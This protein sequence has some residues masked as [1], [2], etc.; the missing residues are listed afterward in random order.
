MEKIINILVPG[1]IVQVEYDD[2]N[3]QVVFKIKEAKLLKN[4]SIIYSSVN[5]GEFYNN[6]ISER[7]FIM[8]RKD[9]SPTLLIHSRVEDFK[10][11][12]TGHLIK[13]IKL[14]KKSK[15]REFIEKREKCNTSCPARTGMIECEKENC[16]FFKKISGALLGDDIVIET[17]GG[18]G[19][20]KYE[21]SF[22]L[23]A[24]D[25][26]DK[27]QSRYYYSQNLETDLEKISNRPY[28]PIT[29]T[30]NSF[31]Y[32]NDFKVEKDNSLLVSPETLVQCDNCLFEKGS[33]ECYGCA[34]K[35]FEVEKV[36]NYVKL[37]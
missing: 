7:D 18:S 21:Y 5:R 35:D 12:P 4:K 30:I 8:F 32:Y 20:K 11:S 22:P 16:E 37:C 27:N 25:I 24:I 9:S 34:I 10:T 3:A 14:I 6:G 13:S 1:D 15:L 2:P 23:V 28:F 26:I 31:R 17:M 33:K 29:N 36:L 19:K